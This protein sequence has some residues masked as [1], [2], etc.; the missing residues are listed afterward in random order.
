MAA[1]GA[2][3]GVSAL[4][5]EAVSNVNPGMASMNHGNSRL[6]NSVLLGKHVSFYSAGTLGSDHGNDFIREFVCSAAFSSWSS[7]TENSIAMDDVFWVRNPF[8]IGKAWISLV[9]VFVIGLF[10]FRAWAN[11][12]F[13]NENV[14]KSCKRMAWAVKRHG[15]IL[16][17][18]LSSWIERLRFN[19]A[20]YMRFSVTVASHSSKVADRIKTFK[21]DNWTPLLNW[22][23]IW[24]RH[25]WPF[26]FKGSSGLGVSMV[27]SIATP[28]FILLASS[29]LVNAMTYYISWA[30]GSDSNAGTSKPSPWKRHP[31]M[32]SFGGAYTH[33]AGDVFVFKGGSANTWPVS[34]FQMLIPAGGSGAGVRDAYTADPTWYSGGSFTRPLFDF[35]STL[36]GPGGWTAGA[37]VLLQAASYVTFDNIELANFRAA[38]EQNGVSLWGTMSITL[39]SCNYFTLT[40]CI[41]R[42]WS[43]PLVSGSVPNGAAGGGA[44]M[45]V[46]S[47]V[48]HIVTHSELH[49]AGIPASARTGTAAWNIGELAF[50]SVHDIGGSAFMYGQ[51]FHDNVISNIT[52]PSDLKAHANVALCP[53]GL[54]AYNNVIHDIEN[55]AL[56]IACEPGQYGV[57]QD[58]IYNNVIWN[59]G[60]PCMQVDTR[61]P[62]STS[63]TS[64]FFNNT[65]VG[66]EG[67]GWGL[68]V[69]NSSGASTQ[70][71]TFVANNNHIISQNAIGSAQGVTVGSSTTLSNLIQTLPAANALGYTTANSYAPLDATKP[72]V[73]AAVD[74]SAYF[75][76]DV[77]GNPRPSAGLWNIGAYAFV[78]PG[79][80]AGTLVLASATYSVVESTPSITVTARRTSGSTGIVGCNVVTANGDALAGVNYTSTST[81]FSW[82]NGDTA[83]QTVVIPILSEPFSG[84]KSFTVTISVP[85][86][87]ATI[88]TPATTTVT[89]TGTAAPPIT[90][91][92]GLGPWLATD[93]D[94]SPPFVASGTTLSQPSLTTTTNDAGVATFR[95]V[96]SSG[97][98]Y[99]ACPEVNASGDSANSFFAQMNSDAAFIWHI[100]PYTVGSESRCVTT[101]STFDT[102]G[103][104]LTW[105]LPSGISTI[106]FSGREAATILVSLTMVLVADEP[107]TDPPM[108]ISTSITTADGYYKATTNIVIPITWSTNVTVTGLP[109]LALN[110]G[111]FGY[112]D[113]TASSGATTVFT[114]VVQAGENSQALDYSSTSALSLN[115]GTIKFGAIDAA[116]TLPAPTTPGSLSYGRTV[117]IDTTTPT[118]TIAIPSTTIASAGSYLFFAI[119]YSDLNYA[120]N[121]AVASDLSI[122]GT[123]T[124]TITTGPNNPYNGVGF[125]LSALTVGTGTVSL[126][127]GTAVDLAGNLAPAAGPSSPFLV[128]SV[129]GGTANV[130]WTKAG[131][132]YAKPTP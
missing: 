5:V 103:T 16:L 64:R 31:F 41:V 21:S 131:L 39:D 9:P 20:R 22:G 26:S 2:L 6:R 90:T 30:D 32:K 36:I 116:L 63:S 93:S 111:G 86:G 62:L 42:D 106:T 76:T 33:A 77:L 3:L 83:D 28:F 35:Q 109:K 92:P 119:T 80:S 72:T 78:T 48:G 7:C 58:L 4:Q 69:G 67:T 98:T 127:A 96:L 89:I 79:A 66:S 55:R 14:N 122:S 129:G 75:T 126:A 105:A 91:L 44:I 57:S 125:T 118:V 17:P 71:G 51:L 59:V 70:L 38:L 15:W 108:V 121:T 120:Y 110:S 81:S 34:C 94:Y 82:A 74:E 54:T 47:G 114:N 68:L 113:A 8:K 53:G 52:N 25:Y 13:K 123:A 73:A 65:V 132:I 107:P 104:L 43:Q 124:A 50:S 102:S 87:G 112:Y 128:T 95:F 84:S 18:A 1:L 85:S 10:A 117:V 37:G 19:T 46:N 97:G 99:K 23:R 27:R 40:N 45:K 88:G 12:R 60:Q 61:W 29:S 56:I 24:I 115:G 49:Q 101:N 130:I 11:K 100:N